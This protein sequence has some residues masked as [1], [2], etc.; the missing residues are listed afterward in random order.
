MSKLNN[1]KGKIKLKKLTKSDVKAKHISWMNDYEVTKYTEQRFYKYTLKSIN[2][3]IDSKLLSRDSILLGIFFNDE[4]IG[5]ILI[6]CVDK[7]HLSCNLSYLI[8]DKKK[9]GQG[10]GTFVVSEAINFIFSEHKLTKISAGCYKIN[11]GSIA[12][13]KN[14]NFVLEGEKKNRLFLKVR[15]LMF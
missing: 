11:K 2:N 9:W 3:Y 14:N 13:L 8:G 15:E 4:H 7:K 10:I 12:V 5:N 6:S 1:I